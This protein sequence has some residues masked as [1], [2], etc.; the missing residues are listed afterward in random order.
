MAMSLH[1]AFTMAFLIGIVPA[2]TLLYFTL[3]SY[4]KYI[5]DK[6]LFFAILTGLFL[7]TLVAF[8]HLAIW[9]S[10]VAKSYS[11]ITLIL[12]IVS[13]AIFEGLVKVVFVQLKRFEAG[14]ETTYYGATFGLII[15]ASVT[16]GRTYLTFFVYDVT[17]YDVVGVLLF[18][19]AI[20]F[21]NGATGAWLGYGHH[22]RD[23]KWS[24]ITV[25]FICM[26]FN[27]M[28]FIWYLFPLYFAPSADLVELIAIA[29][30]YAAAVYLYAYYRIMP[31]AL[32][33]KYQKE[34]LRD[35]R[36]AFRKD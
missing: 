15:G 21:M 11:I 22:K 25:I 31:E 35:A 8:F 20:I 32:P 12:L 27:A 1:N 19:M 6:H 4:E 33:F 10:D 29:L 18:A 26:P 9:G 16:M 28:I 23:L 3:K 36:K 34:R 5:N 7:G 14:F 2:I 30:A 24:F 13:F 17:V